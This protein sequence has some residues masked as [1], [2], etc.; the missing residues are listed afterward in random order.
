MTG[1]ERMRRR[2]WIRGSDVRPLPGGLVTP[3]CLKRDGDLM[4]PTKV[5]RRTLLLGSTA[6]AAAGSESLARLLASA[7]AL[8]VRRPPTERPNVIVI[9]FDDLAWNGFGCYGN[10]FYETPHID[11]LASEGMRFTQAYAAAPVCSPTRA[12]LMTGLFPAR[13]GITHRLQ[14]EEEPGNLYLKPR[15]RTVPE[16]VAERG[17]RSVLIGKW[18]LTEDYSGPYRRRPGNPYVHGFDDV[19]LSEERYISRGDMF[20]PYRFMPIVQRGE[21]GEYLTDRIGRDA[22][23]WISRQADSPFFMHVSNYAVHSPWEAPAALIEKYRRKK[24]LNPQFATNNYVPELAAMVERCDRQVERIVTAVSDAGIAG[25]TLILITSDNGGGR[26]TNRPLRGAKGS[27]YEGGIRVPLLAFWP[28]T[29]PAGTTS[30]AVV[31]TVDMLPTIQH[32]AGGGEV[33]GLDGLSLAGVLT[34][35]DDLTRDTYWYF[36][37]SFGGSVPSAAVRSGRHKLIKQLSTR[38][39][40]LYDIVDDP[41][42]RNNVVE[43]NPTV[44]AALHSMLRDHVQDMRSA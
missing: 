14:R 20:F 2:W 8:V 16:L 27:L 44:A 22:A 34:E 19:L 36:P 30:D 41:G 11:R 13:T 15:F 24:Q 12:A 32:L 21:P 43:S 28:G 29:V 38:S 4:S 40:E 10:E 7:D 33:N 18:H 25:N 17:Y 26:A 35:Q 37:H 39:L 6:A 3:A 23:R 9:S 5:A 1:F 42:E 31:S